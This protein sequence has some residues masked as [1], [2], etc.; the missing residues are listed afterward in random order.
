[1]NERSDQTDA[2]TAEK[3][4]GNHNIAFHGETPP[5]INTD[6]SPNTASK[7]NIMSIPTVLLFEKGAI[8]STSVGALPKETFKKWLEKNL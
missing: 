2:R 5:K 3:V 7:Y 4:P 6:E 1:M 8:K